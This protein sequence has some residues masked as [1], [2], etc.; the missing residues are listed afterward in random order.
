MIRRVTDT[1][2]ISHR[3]ERLGSDLV[4]SI[5]VVYGR[6]A[7][8]T[9][10]PIRQ[11]VEG[12][13]DLVQAWADALM[14]QDALRKEKHLA[15]LGPYVPGGMA[16]LEVRLA[17]TKE[18]DD[19]H[20]ASLTEAALRVERALRGDVERA[21]EGLE[22]R[23]ESIPLETPLI[24]TGDGRHYALYE[25]TLWS[26]TRRLTVEQWLGLISQAMN[27]EEA[28]LA[29]LAALKREPRNHRPA[30]S[31]SVRIEVWRRDGGRCV[32]CGSQA[33]LEF[34]HIIPIALGGGNTG[35][36]IQILCETCN[37]SKSASIS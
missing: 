33:R 10:R 25:G 36:N 13:R 30:I 29:S 28:R 12:L 27:R 4:H 8:M 7:L 26:S 23:M 2:Q 1:V 34:D 22:Q 3:C 15:E 9:Q 19:Q 37:R 24:L 17:R 16:A 21:R 32:Q 35:R 14:A 31:A 20:I 11:D 5:R 18:L 6:K